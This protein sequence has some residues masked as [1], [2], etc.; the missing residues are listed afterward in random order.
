VSIACAN[1]AV[2]QQVLQNP[3]MRAKVTTSILTTK[4]MNV[5][6]KVEALLKRRNEDPENFTMDKKERRS[7]RESCQKALKNSSGSKTHLEA[8]SIQLLQA[9]IDVCNKVGSTSKSAKLQASHINARAN[10]G[11]TCSKRAR[12]CHCNRV[13]T[14]E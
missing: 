13:T 11:C 7:I 1:L 10:L 14:E 8:E 6:A 5:E 4:A 9:G 2:A 12:S 3:E